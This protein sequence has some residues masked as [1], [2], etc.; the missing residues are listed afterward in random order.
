MLMLSKKKK[1]MEKHQITCGFMRMRTL[2]D[3]SFSGF[4]RYFCEYSILWHP[5]DRFDVQFTP[6]QISF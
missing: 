5:G 1:K 3:A 4:I 2:G 6:H